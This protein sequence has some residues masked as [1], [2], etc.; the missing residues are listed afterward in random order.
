MYNPTG[1]SQI[2]P[3]KNRQIVDKR[4]TMIIGPP[5]KFAVPEST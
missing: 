4:L 3:K 5:N 1:Q 2:Q